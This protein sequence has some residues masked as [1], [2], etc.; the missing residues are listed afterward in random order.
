MDDIVFDIA[1]ITESIFSK[2]SAIKATPAL[3]AKAA[4]GVVEGAAE[5][6]Q[7]AEGARQGGDGVGA[8]GGG[9]AMALLRALPL[10][11]RLSPPLD[12]KRAQVQSLLLQQRAATNYRQWHAVCLELDAL[13]GNDAWKRD[14]VSDLY[15]HRVVA[16]NLAQLQRARLAKDHKLLLYLVRT[17]WVRNVG[18]MGNVNL[19]RHLYVGTKALIEDYIAECERALAYLC[20]DASVEL[21]D[22]YL[23]GMLIQ[24]RKNIGRT[25][26][27]LLGGST[28]GIF[29][30]GVLATLLESNMLP[31]IVSGLLAGS[32]MASILCACNNE[33]TVALLETITEKKFEIFGEEEPE[34][35]AG[36]AGAAGGAADGAADAGG[37]AG[38]AA[39]LGAASSLR[40]A[41]KKLLHFLKY[42]TLFDISGLKLT[43]IGFV[44][45]LTFREAY[46]RTGKILNITVL[47][48]LVHE[49]T[50]LLNYLTAPNCLIWL[51]VCALCLLP[52]IFP[53]TSIYEKNRLGHIQEWNNDA[54]V[55]YVDGSV[56]ND[57]PITRLLE[58][59]NVDH[60]IACQVNPH[61]VPFLKMLVTCVGGE[62][63]NEVSSKLKNFLSN[64]YDFMLSEVIHYLEVLHEAGIGLNL[65]T[66]FISIL[67]QQYLGD[68]TILP[69]FN[70]KDFTK[71]FE[72]PT[73]AFLLECIVRGARALWPKLTVVRNHCG[74]EFALDKAI[75]VL[76][77][78]IIT[79][80]TKPDGRTPA[81][82][83]SG[84]AA[85]L[86]LTGENPYNLVSSPVLNKGS[87]S[88]PPAG[89]GA[90]EE[91]VNDGDGER[92]SPAPASQRSAPRFKRH[93]TINA[94]LF[95]H[96]PDDPKPQRNSI[97]A[98]TPDVEARARNAPLNPC[99][100]SV[101]K[102]RGKST[103]SLTGLKSAHANHH[104]ASR[105]SQK[106]LGVE[107][108]PSPPRPALF[109]HGR[110]ESLYSPEADE[111]GLIDDVVGESEGADALSEGE[112]EGESGSERGYRPY[113]NNELVGLGMRA[114]RT[115]GFEH[116]EHEAE[117]TER[118]V[119]KARSSGNFALAQE[120]DHG[121]T[122]RQLRYEMERIPYHKE[123]P[124]LDG[125]ASPREFALPTTAATLP[126]LKANLPSKR[127]LA[128]NSLRNSYVGLNRLKE[129]GFGSSQDLQ[130]PPAYEEH[131]P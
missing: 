79:D 72:N 90:K 62:I 34:A 21:D 86:F 54:L 48:A 42:G 45:D 5:G 46:N 127:A 97:G 123:N 25:A 118:R 44:G 114:S 105:A 111:E 6:A 109:L 69:D 95:R 17:T 68:I 112:G 30:I 76:R 40:R 113:R 89:E 128:T 75:T 70:V 80:T 23:L 98:S 121:G 91:G 29:H 7:G 57:L 73:P 108:S 77:G 3:V 59:F 47:P 58:M 71:I 96:L 32:I 67:L 87:S 14:P 31:R 38:A 56:D 93:N 101:N 18:N 11:G 115:M 65:S 64:V 94:G 104:F 85:S 129:R 1:G 102:A 22:R 125:A 20:H 35:A 83:A 49:Q 9:A 130:T 52:G 78:R 122:P 13:L 116:E 126:T 50:R 74:V 55:K 53:S 106:R 100:P 81:L 37:A 61:V 8:S 88:P 107:H 120:S 19:F 63:E 43:M 41:L 66:K 36:A 103:T 60:I 24:T 28:F 99:F 51:A 39:A 110:S 15:D 84:A 16:H 10:V 82:K 2:H 92:A 27:V 12:P 33:E 119:R 26:L 4:A 131:A 124:Y 117:E